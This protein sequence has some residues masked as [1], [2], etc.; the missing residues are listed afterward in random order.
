VKL[1][2]TA[3]A[4]DP[5]STAHQTLRISSKRY[6]GYWEMVVESGSWRARALVTAGY[7]GETERHIRLGTPWE[8]AMKA[9]SP[10]PFVQQPSSLGRMVVFDD[11]GIAFAGA[12]T[13]EKWIVFSL[14]E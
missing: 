3:V 9:Y 1:L 13:V 10:A 14:G 12:A 8:D 4:L 7:N 5:D 6:P 2:G 11:F